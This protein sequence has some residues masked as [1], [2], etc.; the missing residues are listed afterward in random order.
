LVSGIE[1]DRYWNGM[2]NKGEKATM[3]VKTDEAMKYCVW[4]IGR[5]EYSSDD[6]DSDYEVMI[7]EGRKLCRLTI[8]DVDRNDHDSDDWEVEVEADDCKRRRRRRRRRK[9]QASSTRITSPTSS[10]V[11]FNSG[12]S[13]GII[14]NVNPN[15]SSPIPDLVF[16]QRNPNNK[17]NDSRNSRRGSSGSSSDCYATQSGMV[18]KVT[19]EDDVEALA[20]QEKFSIDERDRNVILSVRT[21]GEPDE[22]T[23]YHRG[24]EIVKAEFDRRDEVCEDYEDAE[25][26]GVQYSQT[27]DGIYACQVTFDQMSEDLEGDW[28]V[29]I[30]REVGRRVET[31]RKAEFEV[32]LD[33]GRGSSRDEGPQL[34]DVRGNEVTVCVDNRD[35]G[36]EVEIPVLFESAEDVE[37]LYW[38][39]DRTKVEERKR[40]TRNGYEVLRTEDGKKR[41]Y[42]VTRLVIEDL[43]RDYLND[44]DVITLTIEDSERNEAEFS[45][46]LDDSRGCRDDQ[47]IEGGDDDDDY[48]CD[49]ERDSD[50]RCDS[51]G[52]NRVC[53]DDDQR[54]CK[55]GTC[56]SECED[57]DDRSCNLCDDRERDCRQLK[58]K[59]P[60]RKYECDPRRDDDCVCIDDEDFCCDNSRRCKGDNCCESCDE[61][62]DD[63]CYCDDD[64]NCV[65]VEKG[66]EGGSAVEKKATRLFVDSCLK[67]GGTMLEVWNPDGEKR[68][69]SQSER[70][71]KE[72]VENF[73]NTASCTKFD[74]DIQDYYEGRSEDFQSRPRNRDSGA[75]GLSFRNLPVNTQPSLMTLSSAG[76]SSAT[77]VSSTPGGKVAQVT[78]TTNALK[79]A[80][81]TAADIT[82]AKK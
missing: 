52:R 29:T 65:I 12:A 3:A 8:F 62:R 77:T 44:E 37:E 10:A 9:R 31:S 43:K 64:D 34:V 45:V 18:L 13:G 21:N 5:S 36:R 26:C 51:T 59:S 78:K 17:Q 66:R 27:S 35:L 25:I 47:N 76:G 80:L 53:C 42:Y 28:E 48:Q 30:G 14:S 82:N 50:C 81:A 4:T 22:C 7:E 40:D 57:E 74:D 70:D 67:L 2:S 79:S 75:G 33:D 23:I 58:S 20:A 54:N 61:R 68:S 49:V 15:P 38:T 71:F 19:D 32:K 16:L 69:S 63:D 24:R 56:C 11:K 72:D 60:Y 46:F 41:D 6:R 1:I 73:F 55:R 39:I